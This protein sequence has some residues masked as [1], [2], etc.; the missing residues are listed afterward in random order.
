MNHHNWL[1]TWI[2]QRLDNQFD[3]ADLT[4]DAFLR[5]YAKQNVDLINEPKAYLVTIAKG[6][7]SQC[8]NVCD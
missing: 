8:I 3:A 5:I 1:Y 2:R 4:Q 7:V 6:L